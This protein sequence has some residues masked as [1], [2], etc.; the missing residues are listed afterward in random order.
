M[1]APRRTAADRIRRLALADAADAP[2]LPGLPV[3]RRMPLQRGRRTTLL[4]SLAERGD[5]G[6]AR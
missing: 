3:T 6:Q 2:A 4:S 5:G 1:T